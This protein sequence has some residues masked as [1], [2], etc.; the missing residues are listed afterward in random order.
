MKKAILIRYGEIHLKGKNR[1]FFERALKN[2]IKRACG[3][4]ECEVSMLGGRYYIREYD[5]KDEQILVDS[6]LKVFGIHSISIAYVVEKDKDAMAQKAIDVARELG[7]T[8]GTFKVD[9]KRADKR[10]KMNSMNL[11]AYIGE[12]NAGCISRA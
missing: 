3:D 6:V 9:A 11:A 12:K 4:I 7:I 8:S 2:Q 5:I 1:P 10:F